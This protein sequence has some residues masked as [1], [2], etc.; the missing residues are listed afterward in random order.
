MDSLSL[1]L[2]QTMKAKSNQH[3]Y[4]IPS[5]HRN[6]FEIAHTD[7]FPVYN[8]VFFRSA[9]FISFSSLC[10]HKSFEAQASAQ[11]MDL[12]E[13]FTSSLSTP[14]R[15]NSDAQRLYTIL[16]FRCSTKEHCY[17]KTKHI[18][19][20]NMNICLHIYIHKRHCKKDLQFTEKRKRKEEIPG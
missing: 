10:G 13:K 18:S 15:K 14:T 17:H 11:H 16:Q 20:R 5:L 8:I 4:I 7:K 1:S 19:N 9:W 12:T 2:M 6:D 3:I